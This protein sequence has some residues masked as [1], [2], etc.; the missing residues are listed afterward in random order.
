MIVKRPIKA[1][2]A[3]AL[4]KVLPFR[5]PDRQTQQV[6]RE[7]AAAW[8]ARLDAA[9]DEPIADELVDWLRQDRQH[10]LVMLEMARLWDQ[11]SLLEELSVIF[12]L[13]NYVSGRR[14]KI[15]RWS[16]GAALAVL[17][18]SSVMLLVLYLS[19]Q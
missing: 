1:K 6:V 10:L 16:A 3:P 14:K 5:R 19:A 17:C 13:E 11:F 4:T 2:K 9:P 18:L 12:P 7:Q 8:L 15:G